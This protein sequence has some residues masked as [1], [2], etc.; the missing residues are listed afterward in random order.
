MCIIIVFIYLVWEPQKR[1]LGLPTP[2]KLP[3]TVCVFVI[4]L[5]ISPFLRTS[6]LIT[7]FYSVVY[8][9]NLYI[10]LMTI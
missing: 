4:L 8:I 2:Q 9:F 3:G 1:V 10:I 6:K 5:A 7:L